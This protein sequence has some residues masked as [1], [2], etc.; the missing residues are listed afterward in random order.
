MNKKILISLSVIGI[1]AAI[2]IGGTI[3][4]FSDTETSENNTFAAGTMDLDIDGDDIAVQTMN[5][6]DKAPGDSGTAN[7]TLKNSGS[8]DGELDVVMGTVTNYPCTDDT[9]GKNDGTEY[10]T[11]DA[12]TL[13]GSAQMALYVD[14]DE[15]GTWNTDDIGLKSDAAKYTN[16]GSTAL[17]YDTID[18]YG[19][20]AWNDVYTGLMTP[21]D[22][23]DFVIDW[24]VPTSATNDIQ[25]DALEFDLTFILEQVDAD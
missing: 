22:Q 20:V 17:D 24:K 3:A 10:C 2:A 16:T 6:L 14:V 12:G 8:L 11:S 18:N 4:Y 25:G 13:G 1:A 19:G 23:D 21:G 7:A 15:S 5:L 9:Y